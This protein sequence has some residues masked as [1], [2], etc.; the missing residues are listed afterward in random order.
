MKKYR[1][2]AEVKAFFKEQGRIGGL[3][4]GR[5]SAAARM[6]NMTAEQRSAVAKKASRAAATKRRLNKYAR[7]CELPPDEFRRR[8]KMA[9]KSDLSITCLKKVCLDGVRAVAE[10]WSES[11]DDIRRREQEA[12]QKLKAMNSL[13]RRTGDRPRVV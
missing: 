1:L 7:I 8:L 3:A 10:E 11:E 5:L 4:G 13:E 6:E 9:A 2:P 12:I